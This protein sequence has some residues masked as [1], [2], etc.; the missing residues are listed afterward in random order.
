MPAA[1]SHLPRLAHCALACLLKTH[2]PR[3]ALQPTQAKELEAAHAEAALLER[4]LF[5]GAEEEQERLVD[6]LMVLQE[7][8]AAA[9]AA[10]GAGEEVA[11]GTAEAAAA[12]DGTGSEAVQAQGDSSGEAGARGSSPLVPIGKGG[13]ICR[14]AS[15]L[16]PARSV[17]ALAACGMRTCSAVLRCACLPVPVAAGLPFLLHCAPVSHCLHSCTPCLQGADP[18]GS[19]FRGRL[20][21]M[22]AD[23]LQKAA[24]ERQRR[25]EEDVQRVAAGIG[26]HG[27]RDLAVDASLAGLFP[28]EACS[29]NPAIVR[30]CWLA[31]GSAWQPRKPR[32]LVACA[33]TDHTP[34][35]SPM[36]ARSTA[37]LPPFCSP[38][39]RA[40]WAGCTGCRWAAVREGA[41][42]ERAG[43]GR[44]VSRH[45]TLR[46]SA[47]LPRR[48][49]PSLVPLCYVQTGPVLQAFH[50][51]GP[52]DS[53]PANPRRLIPRGMTGGAGRPAFVG[54]AAGGAIWR[55]Q[56][57][58]PMRPEACASPFLLRCPSPRC[59]ARRPP[60]HPTVGPGQ[61]LHRVG[62]AP[63]ARAGHVPRGGGGFEG[64]GTSPI[65]G[66]P[67]AARRAC[68][69]HLQ[70][71]SSAA[72]AACL[73]VLPDSIRQVIIMEYR[74]AGL[75]KNLSD[76]PWDY[77]NQAEA[78]EL[79][80]I[81]ESKLIG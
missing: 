15:R 66:G 44:A 79:E 29:F 16:G 12:E 60:A 77:Y 53:D 67:A 52:F 65:T 48:P 13:V 18:Y 55:R 81:V 10:E 20:I 35:R 19:F 26:V 24:G 2:L 47:Q 27:S 74:G 75:S 30:E 33:S 25:R 45:A 50:R 3:A 39:P 22:T 80:P 62:R 78:R 40:S 51:F 11:E 37:R 31:I 8:D 36:H 70:W 32:A 21:R 58:H 64:T 17:S 63:A 61:H 7:E 23:R 71:S 41:V 57:A 43:N 34:P 54:A 73:P 14:L 69:Q 56:P 59:S 49:A 76:Q 68:S 38:T 4:R 9:A 1:H 5:S 42:H 28:K 46:C 6:A 72:F